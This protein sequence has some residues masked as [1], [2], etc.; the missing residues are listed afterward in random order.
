ML[1]NRPLHPKALADLSLRYDRAP[2]P[3]VSHKEFHSPSADCTLGLSDCY[4][5]LRRQI[6]IRRCAAAVN[7]T[8]TLV[9]SRDPS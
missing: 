2:Q 9:N 6:T 8:K 3:M 4:H 7:L 1:A 5:Y